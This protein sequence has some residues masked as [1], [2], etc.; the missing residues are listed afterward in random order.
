MKMSDG[1]PTNHKTL[2]MNNHISIDVTNAKVC[3]VPKDKF[4]I[5]KY[6]F[7][8]PVEDLVHNSEPFLHFQVLRPKDE[9]QALGYSNPLKAIRDHV[10]E[11][12][13]GVNVSFPPGG[14]QKHCPDS[15]HCLRVEQMPQGQVT[16]R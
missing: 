6:D 10:D 7:G 9:E 4:R 1:H 15:G 16:D 13:K 11:E 5:N 12:D 8:T 14:K 2:K 3:A